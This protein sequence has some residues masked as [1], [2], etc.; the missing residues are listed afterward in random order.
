VALKAGVR[1][2]ELICSVWS[3]GCHLP[4]GGFTGQRVGGPSTSRGG[5]PWPEQSR[6]LLLGPG[7]RV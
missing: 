6:G 3:M 7:W 5:Y 1:A 2:F 4:L